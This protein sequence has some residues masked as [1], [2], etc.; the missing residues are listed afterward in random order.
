MY[1]SVQFK[2]LVKEGKHMETEKAIVFL[3]LIQE[4]HCALSVLQEILVHDEELVG[5]SLV[6]DLPRRLEQLTPRAQVWR[7]F[8]SEKM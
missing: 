1:E 3:H 5:A 6:S 7:V 2:G 4:F 8:F